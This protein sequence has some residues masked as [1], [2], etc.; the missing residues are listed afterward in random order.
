MSITSISN[1]SIVRNLTSAL[2][3][4]QLSLSELSSQLATQKKHTDL[5]DYSA[6]DARNLIDLQAAGTQCDAYISVIATAST[7]LSIYDTIMT[8]LEEII[9]QAQSLANNN[10][11]YT[12]DIASNVLIQTNNYLKSVTVDLNQTINGRY[13]LSGSRYNTQPVQDLS[14]LPLSTLDT[15]IYTDNL[16][17]PSYDT[18]FVEG[19]GSTSATAYTTDRAM[20]D[21]GYIVDYG[22]TS[23]DPAIQKVV[24]GLRYLQA[25]G[26]STDTA[27]YKSNMTQASTLLASGLAQ[28]QNLHTNIANNVNVMAMEKEAQKTEISNLTDRVSNIQQVDTTEIAIKITSFQSVLQASYSATGSILKMSIVNYL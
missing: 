9:S 13:I 19:A 12:E 27:T 5:T 14:A 20:I 28:I 21:D 16:T 7:N 24:M 26:N 10:P 25:A 17:L 15:T 11:T 8:D 18:E 1:L 4:Q 3:N 2:Q 22:I 6:N 23:N